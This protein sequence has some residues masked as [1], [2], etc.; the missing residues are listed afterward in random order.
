MFLAGRIAEAEVEENDRAQVE[1]DLRTQLDRYRT[2]V[3][4]IPAIT[5]FEEPWG[6]GQKT[7]YVSPQ[8]ESILG[9]TP[10]EWMASEDGDVW[11]RM[12]H[13]DD[14]DRVLREYDDWKNGGPD[15]SDYRMIKRDGT[16]VWIHD[17]ASLVLDETG[18]P[19][20]WHG[21]MTDVTARKVAEAALGAAEARYRTLVEE[22]PGIVYMTEPGDSG[23]WLYVSPQ[24]QQMLGF[25]PKEWMEHPHPFETYLHPD[26][27][28][29]VREEEDNAQEEED[30]ALTTVYRLYTREGQLLWIRDQSRLVRDPSGKVMFLQGVML[31]ITDQKQAEEQIAFLAYHDPL[32]GLA[33][34]KMFEEMLEPAMARARRKDLSVAVLFMDLD[35]FKRVNDTL[36]HD[37]GDLLL[38]QVSERLREATRDTDLVARQ[39]GDEFLVM[40][41]DVEADGPSEIVD[42]RERVMRVAEVMAQRIHHA[43]SVP[44]ALG[45]AEVSSSMSVGISTF[46]LDAE[47][48]RTLLK[49]ADAAM[50]ESKRSHP[51]AFSFSPRTKSDPLIDLSITR[52]LR[53]AVEGNH[54]VLHYQPWVDLETGDIE[55][56]E[57]LLRWRRPKGELVPA[58]E[59]ISVAEEMGLMEVIGEWVV[60]ELC[61]QA[62]TW[63]EQ[64]LEPDLSFNLSPR[65]LWHRDFAQGLAG[66]FKESGISPSRVMVEISE[67]TAATDPTRAQRILNGLRDQG[68]R[69]AIDDFGTGYSP[70]GRL[71]ALPV[72]VLK[73]DHP[74]VRDLP[75][76]TEVAGFVEAVVAF[77]SELHITCLA[78]GIETPEQRAFLLERGCRLGQGYLFSRPVDGQQITNLFGRR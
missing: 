16:E 7:V 30:E 17:E 6:G 49:H 51:G 55:G 69:I 44:F 14:R 20:Y 67:A 56:V 45:D 8:I 64:G 15:L 13:P 52:R 66:A 11:V 25:T 3:E 19:K 36:G 2:H 58:A 48:A 37:M 43:M 50:Y 63:R 61:S 10:E 59:F 54:W 18:R 31:D 53:E 26:D 46:P 9:I 40:I 35:D 23:D 21:V 22:L 78:E 57:A 68:M 4:Q 62:N 24:I 12:L 5:Y 72:D 75:Q 41:P 76:D 28:Q 65:Q 38:K 70:P 60:K 73:I 71:K 33:N 74:L 1:Q 29:R 34:R 32:T 42:D 77:A 27:L 39:G 47:D